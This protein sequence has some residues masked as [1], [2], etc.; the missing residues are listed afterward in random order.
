M[1][2]LI[3]YNRSLGSIV[4][5]RRFD[6]SQRREAEDARLE[7]ELSLNRNGVE[8]E[9]V[10]LDAESEAMLRKANRRYFESLRQILKNPENGLVHN[11]PSSGKLTVPFTEEELAEFRKS[12]NGASLAEVLQKLDAKG[13]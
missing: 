9:V 6:D 1:I 4:E 12:A 2:F 8:H 5:M 7:T 10:L 3:E 11:S 13:K